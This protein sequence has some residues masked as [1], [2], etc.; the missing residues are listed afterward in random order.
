M[1][2]KFFGC[3][4]SKGGGLYGEGVCVQYA[5]LGVRCVRLW[6]CIDASV[7]VV[8]QRGLWG[9]LFKGHCMA[10]VLCLCL[11]LCCGG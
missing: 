2:T 4:I 10:S 9:G 6:V 5:W 3:Y 11:C 8:P 7:L 1:V